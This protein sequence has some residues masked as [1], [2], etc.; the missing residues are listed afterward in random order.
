MSEFK[1]KKV[2]AY[3]ENHKI[4]EN[5]LYKLCSI[6]N[7]WLPCTDKYFYKNNKSK[8]DG[9][10]PYC[11]ECNKYK[12]KKWIN[13][14]EDKFRKYVKIRDANLSKRRITQKRKASIKQRLSGYQSEYRKNNK[15]KI[16]Q[17]NKK[18]GHKAHNITKQQWEACKEYFNYSCAYCEMSEEEHKK[19]YN[20]QLH[21]EHIIDCGRNDL[22]NCVPACRSCNS[23]KHIFSFNDWYNKNNP[24]YLKERYDKIVKWIKY[25][26]KIVLN[27]TYKI[28]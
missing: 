12:F 7:K 28:I 13:K 2:L 16:K 8:K 23:E 6:C 18:Y 27:N 19:I 1:N 20:Q 5:K 10:F 9:L 17:Y 24:N 11:K 21:K 4:I 22:K 15:D 3:E 26:C 14:N 25:D